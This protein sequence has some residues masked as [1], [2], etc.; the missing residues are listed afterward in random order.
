MT[1][2]KRAV[3]V[4]VL[5]VALLAICRVD[6]EGEAKS[7]R[8]APAAAAAGPV[9]QKVVA[10]PQII[11]M[12]NFINTKWPKISYQ[13]SSSDHIISNYQRCHGRSLHLIKHDILG[14]SGK[15]NLVG[16]VPYIAL[17]NLKAPFQS[18][19]QTPDL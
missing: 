10:T 8:N 13:I 14:I 5:A 15:T 7:G 11:L 9:I 6:A 17:G 3:V 18:V 19:C 12:E 1:L 4:A 16:F 2:S